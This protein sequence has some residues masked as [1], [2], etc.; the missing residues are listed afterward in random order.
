MIRDGTHDSV[1][2]DRSV[3]Q[4]TDETVLRLH[5]KAEAVTPDGRLHAI[6]T[7]PYAR[8]ASSVYY[9]HRMIN[10]DSKWIVKETNA[11]A[12]V[13]TEPVGKLDIYPYH[14]FYVE[15]ADQLKLIFYTRATHTLQICDIDRDLGTLT[16]IK[17]VPIPTCDVERNSVVSCGGNVLFVA[18]PV[19]YLY[20]A[21]TDI[22]TTVD[23]PFS[24]TQCILTADRVY[25]VRSYP[26]SVTAVFRPIAA[27]EG[28]NWTDVR[29]LT[30]PSENGV[31]LVA[32]VNGE[33]TVITRN[34]ADDR[35]LLYHTYDQTRNIWLR[36][37]F[38][39]VIEEE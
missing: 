16:Q 28:V 23:C 21:V 30:P 39:D 25:M 27:A 15:H 32:F 36:H 37:A 26:A 14:M 33:F 11:M 3:A 7:V 19:C 1:R 34:L 13:A 31:V 38:G 20:D 4:S 2:F 29:P 35:T 9:M 12:W 10:S 8:E 5:I 24:P 18:A 17:D 6:A 22:V